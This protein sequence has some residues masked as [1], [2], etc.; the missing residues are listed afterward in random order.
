[1]WDDICR[2]MS[3][4]FQRAGRGAIIAH[5]I[6]LI[7]LVCQSRSSIA[8]LLWRA[9][10]TFTAC[11]RMTREEQE[12]GWKTVVT[13]SLPQ[14]AN[15][16]LS[17]SGTNETPATCGVKPIRIRRHILGDAGTFD[18]IVVGVSYGVHQ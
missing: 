7:A 12:H 8:A 17:L 18:D 4:L 3:E 2:T 16:R 13:L 10:H 15:T 6:E 11:G 5:L 9:S 14:L 1:M